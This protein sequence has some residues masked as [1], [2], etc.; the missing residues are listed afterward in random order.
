[1]KYLLIDDLAQEVLGT[2]SSLKKLRESKE[3]QSTACPIIIELAPQNREKF[4]EHSQESLR[5]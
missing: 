3:Y 1:M 2:F 5:L 4:I